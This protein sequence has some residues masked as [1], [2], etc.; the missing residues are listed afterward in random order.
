M[1]KGG[2]IALIVFFIVLAIPAVSHIAY[3]QVAD[4]DYDGVPDDDDICPESQT[5]Q[6]DQ[7]GCSCAQKNCLSDNNPCTD[8]CSI[9]NAG[10]PSCFFSDNSNSCP[11]GYCSDG[12]CKISGG[13]GTLI[14][15][16]W[17]DDNSNGKWDSNEAFIRDPSGTS[18]ANEFIQ[19]GFGVEYRGPSSGSEKA[20]KCNPE[21]YYAVQLPSGNYK[22]SVSVP[23]GWK[24]TAGNSEAVI[25]QNKPNHQWFGVANVNVNTRC[26]DGKLDSGEEC[27]AGTNN[28][29]CP[30]ACSSGCVKNTCQASEEW[31]FCAREDERC[32]FSGTKEVR[33][34]E[35]GKF[36]IGT[37]TDG[38]DC[39]N[40]VFG[41]PIVGIVKSCYYR[42]VQI[43]LC[44]NNNIDIGEDCDDGTNNGACP[45]ACSAS[46][47]A[48]S[49]PRDIVIRAKSDIAKGQ[50][51][52]FDVEVNGN[53][54][55]SGTA[56]AATFE[57]YG[58]S[59]SGRVNSLKVIFTNDY[60][61]PAAGE[62]R[63]LYI[64]YVIIKGDK[65][66]AENDFD[67]FV[68]N[69]LKHSLDSTGT[70]VMM[71]WNGELVLKQP[72]ACGN[73]KKESNEDC[74]GDDLDGKKCTSFDSYSGGAL[75]CSS[76]CK[77][78]KSGCMGK[79]RCGDGKID[80]G[81]ECDG[82]DLNGKTCQSLGYSGGSLGCSQSCAFI[83]SLCIFDESNYDL[84]N[85]GKIDQKDFEYMLDIVG[86]NSACPP[87]KKCDY[88]KNGKISVADLVTMI[89]FIN[90]KY[91]VNADGK[92]DISDASLI[93]EILSGNKKCT[94]KDICDLDLD[95]NITYY[96]KELI[97]NYL[98]SKYNLNNDDKVDASDIYTLKEVIAGTAKCPEKKNCD[99]DFDNKTSD[100]DMQALK[101]FIGRYWNN[102]LSCAD[103]DNG[104]DYE[105][106][107]NTTKSN[108][109]KY[110]AYDFIEG[111]FKEGITSGC[112]LSSLQYC[113]EEN[114]TRAQ[115]AVLLLKS[116]GVEPDSTGAQKFKDVPPSH[117]A[118]GYIQVF[119]QK[120]FATECRS[121]PKGGLD[122]LDYCPDDIVTRAQLAAFIVSAL[123]KKPDSSG[124]QLFS[125]TPSSHYAYGFVQKARKLGIAEECTKSPLNFCP[126]RPAT[127]AETAVV[128]SR[129]F[130]IEPF[131]NPQASFADVPKSISSDSSYD[132]CSNSLL[133]EYYCDYQ[134]LG[135][136]EYSC[137]KKC[138]D[139]KCTVPD[140]CAASG[141]SSSGIK[142]EATKPQSSSSFAIF[143]NP[144]VSKY[145]SK[146]S[147]SFDEKL[148]INT[149]EIAKSIGNSAGYTKNSIIIENNGKINPFVIKKVE[150]GKT[151]I[152][153]FN[154][155]IVELEGPSLIEKEN[156]L[157]GIAQKNEETISSMSNLNP[158]KYVYKAFS[159]QSSDVPG[160]IKT[161]KRDLKKQHEEI[162]GSIRKILDNGVNG[163]VTGNAVATP[164]AQI[165]AAN[166]YIKVYNGFSVKAD[167]E[168]IRKISVIKGVKKVHPNMEVRLN[169]NESVPLIRANEVWKLDKDGNDCSQSGK[170]CL[171]GKNVIIAVIDTGVDYTHPD[172]GGCFGTR[173]KVIGG[174]DF[175]ND[176]DDPMDD[177]GHGTH[178]AA[179]AAGNGVLKGAAPDA[180]IISYKVLDSGGSGSFETVLAGIERAVDPNNDGDYSDHVNVISMSLG[181]GCW[182]Y[183]DDCGPNDPLSKAIDN[184]ADAGVVSVIA[185]GNS[186]PGKG[187]I[188]SPGTARKAIT[189]GATDKNLILADFSSRGPVEFGDESISKPDV[190]APGVSI[191]AAKSSQ[192]KIAPYVLEHNGIDLHC[193][194]DKHISISGTSMATP[195]VSGAAALLIQSHPDWS[196]QQVKSAL[197]LSAKDLGYPINE[198]GAGFIDVY[199]ANKID[200]FIEPASINFGKILDKTPEPR[201]IKISNHRNKESKLNLS[202]DCGVA[203]LSE[204]EIIL[205]PNSSADIKL[206]INQLPAKEGLI[207]SN[208]HISDGVEEFK[209]P[210][211]LNL[212]S[213]VTVYVKTPEKAPQ[214]DYAIVSEKLDYADY[215]FDDPSVIEKNN[216]I[217]Y[218][219][220]GSYIV[221]AAGDAQD[222]YSNEYLLMKQATIPKNKRVSVT[223]DT[224]EARKFRIKARSLDGTNLVLY[225]WQKA[226][227]TY[228]DK[229]CFFG[230]DLTDPNYGDRIVYVSNSPSKSLDTDIFFKY[231]GVPS[232]NYTS[233][234]VRGS[235]SRGFSWKLCEQN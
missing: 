152:T 24:I 19:N 186:G 175:I 209:I 220:S 51:A 39:S 140:T 9:D 207:N 98:T 131:D 112:S 208:V 155:Y 96:D 73:G 120:G 166:E 143:V 160:K 75:K 214:S 23:S 133:T 88:N 81:E 181:A 13:T 228:N 162:N 148:G 171:T 147:L 192:D 231:D 57:E 227:H 139:G 72:Q 129:A 8:D 101:E 106:K 211:T 97:V 222:V 225:E 178:V 195:H 67:Y 47:T 22:I 76:E 190:L 41:D 30:N 174:H 6:V 159:T 32:G 64:D 123:D 78:D 114:L 77:F 196:A 126:D 99:F 25:E 92:T 59:F 226:Y 85:D 161:Y 80:A 168:E 229:G 146:F 115:I 172:L 191:C 194:D 29:P 52:D 124:Y 234:G 31:I 163:G 165:G 84:T 205:K 102:G 202:T 158:V 14:G 177:H 128:L 42:S 117:Y 151:S 212:V 156:A 167:E 33:Y 108:V 66:E 87:D 217:F 113:P 26:G 142:A 134:W 210:F 21:P 199:K 141:E 179:T 62:D 150:S 224:D 132:F 235:S 182:T 68:G 82:A 17:K 100:L 180:K 206:Y 28:G 69:Q 232:K 198:Q 46:C 218:V 83:T 103:S 197:I 105:I 169:L 184:A 40:S 173:C 130:K 203:S 104:K 3:S 11:N 136:E 27:D 50:G 20:N 48:N 109:E 71:L 65:K 89:I 107:G 137:P 185:A 157:I 70:S 204:N 63:N 18:C 213:E 116:L 119:Y 138:N 125:D 189:I 122:Y 10:R 91:D 53:K 2:Y 44:G 60:Y 164:N 216:H 110:W 154:S 86:G 201:I 170:E 200:L 7:F 4:S 12:Q 145:Q 37:Y 58:F 221:Y 219:T 49:C 188:G 144:Q 233:N 5:T 135:S 15:R 35:D 215:F 153:S 176:D 90:K 56:S 45:K 93:E 183:N 16:I 121:Y 61:N 79:P 187:T 127:M 111:L 34:G 38:V 149:E 230:Y 193:L 94:E 223:L 36:F 74:D 118:Y 54:I 95:H 1:K 43:N 55:G